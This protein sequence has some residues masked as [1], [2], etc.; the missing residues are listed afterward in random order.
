VRFARDV[1]GLE[2]LATEHWLLVLS[3]AL[4]YL[5]IVEIGKAIHSRASAGAQIGG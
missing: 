3:I 2:P 5:V 4:G 1:V